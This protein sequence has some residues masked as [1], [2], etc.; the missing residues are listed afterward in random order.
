MHSH[1][2]VLAGLALQ[3]PS[4]AGGARA[5]E[6]YRVLRG[7]FSEA[8]GTFRKA[9]TSLKS[10]ELAQDTLIAW[11]NLSLRLAF[12]LLRNHEF[13]QA[14]DLVEKIDFRLQ[15]LDENDRLTFLLR[16]EAA[17]LKAM[18][19]EF[20]YLNNQDAFGHYQV[21]LKWMRAF[22][23]PWPLSHSLYRISMLQAILENKHQTEKV[24]E[25]ALLL[26]QQIGDP[27]L[28]SKIKVS[29]LYMYTMSGQNDEAIRMAQEL[30]IYFRR[31]GTRQSLARSAML[32]G[33]SFSHA[34]QFELSNVHMDKALTLLDPA[35]NYNDYD[36]CAYMHTWNC[37]YLGDYEAVR[38]GLT[39]Y[40]HG[41]DGVILP[42]WKIIR[43]YLYLLDFSYELAEADFNGFVDHNRYI[44]RLDVLGQGLGLLSYSAYLTRRYPESYQHLVQALENGLEHGYFIAIVI[45]LQTL[46]LI[47]A[48][49]EELEQAA[50]LFQFL[51]SNFIKR[52]VLFEELFGKRI[53]PRLGALPLIY[54]P[55]RPWIDLITP[56]KHYLEKLKHSDNLFDALASH[57]FG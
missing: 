41:P 26:Q 42:N 33:L 50:A 32:L 20:Y 52:T 19:G 31:V 48:E 9:L 5:L 6:Y 36:F 27:A 4:L 39:C 53:R 24:A 18:L 34:M 38:Q 10:T 13:S 11:V 17:M 55:E 40:G 57:R 56:A 49:T 12:S 47:L 25:E 15:T 35:K 23:E 16:G 54:Q 43:G 46:D 8:I 37:L 51:N 22:G 28:T 7:G 14:A 2:P 21:C 45:S 3:P 44:Q 30:D 29:L 1:R